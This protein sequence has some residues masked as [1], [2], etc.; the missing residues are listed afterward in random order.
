MAIKKVSAK[1]VICQAGQEL[2]E[3][4]VISEGTVSTALPGGEIIL[5]K[6]D[7]LGIQ[8]LESGI[9]SCACTSVTDVSLFT[10]PYGNPQAFF[11]RA[12][13]NGEMC[14]LF[15]TT[16][17][18]FTAALLNHYDNLFGI[19]QKI[20]EEAKQNYDNYKKICSRFSLSP[21][22]LPGLDSLEPFSYEEAIESWLFP[23]YRACLEFPGE[24]KTAVYSVPSFA[25]GF[26]R[27]TS[28]DIFRI[29]E[30]CR[31]MAEYLAEAHALFLNEN[32]L[33]FFD[34][35]ANLYFRT[36]PKNG[37]T[38]AFAKKVEQLMTE[39]K[40][41]SFIDDA[42]CEQRMT[43]YRERLDSI[44]KQPQNMVEAGADITKLVD[45]LHTILTYGK[46]D[47]TLSA[48]FQKSIERYKKL[49]DKNDVGEQ[50]KK[51]RH[52]LT[53][54]FYQVYKAVF[55]QSLTGSDMPPAVK[56][57]LH[58]GYIDETLAGEE[59]AAYLLSLADTFHGAPGYG[60]YTFYEWLTAI[61][62]GEKEPSRNEFD[63]DYT[64]WLHE[65]KATGKISAAE[66]ARLSKDC[67]QKVLFELDNLFPI[68]N[69][70]T[71]GRITTF[72]PL[73]SDH[74]VLKEPATSLV[75]PKKIVDALNGIRSVDFSAFYRETIY[76]NEE[77]NV[78]R[79]YIEIEVMPDIILM[80]NMGTRG[81]MWQEIEGKR[82]TTPA[83][84]MIPVFSLEDLSALLIRL[85]A[86]Y[87]WEM[88]KRIQGVHWNDVTDPSL[89]SEYC[90]YAQFYRKNHELSAAAKEKIKNSLQK[91]KNNYRE[92]FVQDYIAWVNFEGKGSPRL[93][94]P[95]R[96]I[97]FNYCP[98]PEN[99]RESLKS[100]PL[101]REVLER[102]DLKTGQ[103]KHHLQNVC[104]RIEKKKGKVPDTLKRQMNYLER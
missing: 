58:F 86:E 10:Y 88:C 96:N 67:M 12:M 29:L 45:S 14:R 53:T 100:N 61:F 83:R 5:K 74:N 73:F 47:E 66:E 34:L 13:E 3:L 79:E 95:A 82:R 27:K 87:R 4:Y 102:Y 1:N 39:A 23:Y 42:L 22:S 104:S 31:N 41:S 44:I 75:S 35:Y 92:M 7:V 26:L 56:L 38:P 89:T 33:D 64:A 98:F 20:Y 94:K 103:K 9:Y 101:Y 46:C 78:S 81:I 52:S 90:D 55:L 37:E 32:R 48:H 25:L 99:I 11:E 18:G 97:L 60:V 80:P 57:F 8:D 68:A 69:K 65:Q 51:L 30:F 50:A 71:F 40:A 84:M 15:L 93:N 85:T 6:G 43:E 72:C 59:N 2:S 54:D 70:I 19:C 24:I 76:T 62:E 21:K 91:A 28:I 49:L 77:C 63:T 36:L 16:A 17:M